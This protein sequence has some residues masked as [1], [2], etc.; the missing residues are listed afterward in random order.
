VPTNKITSIQKHTGPASLK[1]SGLPADFDTEDSEGPLCVDLDGSLIRTDLLWES[2]LLLFRNKPSTIF[3]SILWVFQ[4]RAVLKRQIAIRVNLKAALVP[5]NSELVEWLR[6]ERQDGRVLI[7]ATASDFNL[8]KTV[9][10]FLDLFDDLI[11]SD[12][13]TN[14]K[15]GNKLLELQNRYGRRFTYIGDARADLEIWS[16]CQAAVLV[17]P[18]RRTEAKARRVTTV[19]RVF[20]DTSSRPKLLLRALRLHQ[21]VKNL[22]I[23]VPL[24]SSHQIGNMSRLSMAIIAF[25]SFS[26]CASSI[27]LINDAL[28]IDADRQHTEKRKRPFASGKLSLWYG[29]AFLPILLSLSFLL[30]ATISVQF[31]CLVASYLILTS[32]YSFWLKKQLLIDVFALASLYTLRIIAGSVAYSIHLSS[33]LLAF[34]V[35]LFLSLGFC[36]RAAEM[37]NLEKE[38]KTELSGG[39][40]DLSD[41]PQVNL[42]GVTS[43]FVASLVLALYMNSDSMRIL[44]R[45]QEFLWLAC[46]LMLF[47]LSRMWLLTSRGLMNEDPIVFAA[48]DR[49][50]YIVGSLIFG[51]MIFSTYLGQE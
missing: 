14:R 51:L 18:S 15:G 39:A 37:K 5:Y 20:R 27:Y 1:R 9:A 30:A 17:N 29:A 22:L 10:D 36:K 31:V 34:S 7:L 21:W 11:A 4:G 8:A 40:Y 2:A 28:D 24:I 43:G 44:Y 41:L 42:F 6:R 47:W 12:G 48:K 50:T 46:P 16:N 26:L 32:L 33:W 45:N 3:R 13:T 38:G 25:F 49:V 35:F 19:L 23:F